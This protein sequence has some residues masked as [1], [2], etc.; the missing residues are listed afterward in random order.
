M[1]EPLWLDLSTALGIH[2]MMIAQYGGSS[3]VRDMSVLESGLMRPRNRFHYGTEDLHELAG[4]Y[5]F[6]V[7][8]NHPFVDGNKRTGFMLSAVFLELNGW[9]LTAPEAE[10][11]TFTLGLA[12]HTVSEKR[13]GDWLRDNSMASAS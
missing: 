4:G 11:V 7:V 8:R 12:D 3:G 5:A 1:S 9:E 6:G 13:Y 10:A 2:E